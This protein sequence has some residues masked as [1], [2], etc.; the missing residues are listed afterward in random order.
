MAT[1][2]CNSCE[3]RDGTPRTFE[4]DETEGVTPDSNENGDAVHFCPHCGAVR[5]KCEET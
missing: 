3:N 4:A 2:Q 1:F 5:S